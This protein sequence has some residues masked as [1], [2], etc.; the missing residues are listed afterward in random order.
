[1]ID[2]NIK[3]YLCNLPIIANDDTVESV[4]FV[5]SLISKKIL[6][7]KYKKVILWNIRRKLKINNVFYIFYKLSKRRYKLSLSKKYDK[8]ALSNKSIFN[9]LYLNPYLKTN[10]NFKLINVF[11]N[12]LQDY[13]KGNNDNYFEHLLFNKYKIIRHY[14]SYLYVIR[15]NHYYINYIKK[16]K[17]L[18][19]KIKYFDF[20]QYSKNKKWHKFFIFYLYLFIYIF[21]SIRFFYEVLFEPTIRNLTI[22]KNILKKE[23]LKS[24]L[25][26]Y[27]YNRK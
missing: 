18:L 25:Y 24:S 17:K 6:L 7:L 16:P 20:A 22:L 19:Y 1:M 4:S 15:K 5:L 13:K 23:K 21:K 11:Y 10:K 8:V 14:K 2:S 12:V 9:I 27:K 26:L 3:T